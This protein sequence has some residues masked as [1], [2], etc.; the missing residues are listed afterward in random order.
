MPT[1]A[2]EQIRYCAAEISDK[3]SGED[4]RRHAALGIDFFQKIIGISLP[5]DVIAAAVNLLTQGDDPL[6][7]RIVYFDDGMEQYEIDPADFG[8]FEATGE[9]V[10]PE[11]GEI[12][13]NPAR[14]LTF[15]WALRSSLAEPFA[16][17]PTEG[18]G[19]AAAPG[20]LLRVDDAPHDGTPV[21]MTIRPDLA[22]FS[23]RPAD[24]AWAGLTLVMRFREGSWEFAAPF[25]RGGWKD[26][27]F[28]GWTAST[29]PGL[30]SATLA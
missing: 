9:L 1:G 26:D 6:L 14:R 29:A 21:L 24:S 30:A 11:T 12:I 25:G 27:D 4:P 13:A 22:R 19:F 3:L 5:V 28:Q 15:S 10:H 17:P 2:S 16:L 20:A 18:L 8:C 23:G 7:E